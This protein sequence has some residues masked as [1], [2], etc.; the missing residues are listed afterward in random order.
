MSSHR[1]APEIS[2]DPVADSTDLYAFVSP[3]APGTVTLIANYV[4]L[5]GPAGG[6]NFYEFGDD[7]LYEI[8]IDNDGDGDVDITY[9]FQFTTSIEV[10]GTFLYN[11]GPIAALDSPQLESPAVLFGDPD[12]LDPAARRAGRW[13]HHNSR[14]HGQAITQLAVEPSVPAVQRRPEVDAQL[15]GARRTPRSRLS[16]TVRRCSPGSGPRASTSTSGRSSTSAPSGR[17]SSSTSS[18]A[19]QRDGGER[20]EGSQRALDRV[21]GP[22]D[23]PDRRRQPADRSEECALG[24]RRVDDGV[25]ATRALQLREPR[26]L[27]QS[28]ERRAVDPGLTPGQPVVQRGARADGAQGRLEQRL[29]VRRQPVRRRRAAPGAREAAPGPLPGRV[30]E[31]GRA[32]RFGQAAVP[33]SPRSCSP[34][35]RP[36]SSART[37]RTSRA[38]RRPTCCA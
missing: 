10:G 24:D 26:R 6:P 18:D 16:P 7:V 21:A 12:R 28:G 35:S 27:E 2:K 29:A 8:N 4:P 37:S 25:P 38:P 36:A 23:A 1:E 30:P 11:V 32:R 20:N 9:Q 17:S 31:P 3:D 19:G 34:A 33:T 14:R 22:D 5:Q 15:R 13:R